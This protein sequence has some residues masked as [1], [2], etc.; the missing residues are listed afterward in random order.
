MD[1]ARAAFSARNYQASAQL[2]QQAIAMNPNGSQAYDLLGFINFYQLGNYSEGV[3]LMQQA[4]AKG[5]SATFLVLHDMGD[6]SFSNRCTGYLKV[7][8]TQVSFR[9]TSCNGDNFTTPV[10]DITEARPNRL[11]RLIPRSRGPRDLSVGAVVANPFHIKTIHSNYNLAGS[12]RS[13]K[14]EM[15]AILDL[16]GRR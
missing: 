7:S 10:S 3:N 4:V 1:Q 14:A 9:S 11:S 15:D 12:S 6:G 16:V 2:A 13:S 5:G 8:K